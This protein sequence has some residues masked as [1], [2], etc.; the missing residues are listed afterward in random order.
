[1][2]FRSAVTGELRTVAAVRALARQSQADIAVYG[3]DRV[4][5][6][7]T[8]VDPASQ[9]PRPL[10]MILAWVWPLGQPHDGPKRR[11]GTL[12]A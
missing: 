5:G 8:H 11:G 2:I 6:V 3:T 1:M 7:N 12:Y 4:L 10:T 9:F